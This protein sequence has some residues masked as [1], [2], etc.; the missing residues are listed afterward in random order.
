MLP[1]NVVWPEI[2]TGKLAV[3]PLA[4]PAMKVDFGVIRL[5]HRTLSPLG[6]TFVRLLQ[7]VDAELCD[8]EQRNAPKVLAAPRRAHSKA[9]SA[10]TVRKQLSLDR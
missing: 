4:V 7:E 9:R 2:Q 10:T 8:F 3:L 5:A 6:E 1:L